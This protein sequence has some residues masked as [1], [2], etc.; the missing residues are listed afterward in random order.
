MRDRPLLYLCLVIAAAVMLSVLCGGERFVR[1]LRPSALE[2]SVPEGDLAAV[3]GQVYRIEQKENCQALYLEKNFVKYR[4]KTEREQSCREG[5][6]QEEAYQEQSIREE[7]N[8]EEAYRE[9]SVREEANQEQ[10]IREEAYQEE[11]FQ[12]SRIII[13]TDSEIQFQI[14]NRVEAKGEV[15]FFQGARNPGNFDQKRYYQ[16]L[17]IHG[18]IW[19]EDI[20]IVD[21]GVQKWKARLENFRKRWMEILL[22]NF[23]EEDG[24]VM[25]AV[26]LGEKSEVDQELKTLY[27]VNG[28]GHIIA[29][30]GLHLSFIGIGMY[31]LLRRI[32]GS[33]PIGGI[34]GILFLMLYILMIG[35]TVSA[36]RAL[37]MFLFRVGADMAGRHYDA[38]TALSAAAVVVLVWRP[39]SLYD[40]GFWLSFGAVLAIL[41]VVPVV[42]EGISMWVFHNKGQNM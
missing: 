6:V 5:S 26:M 16:I 29:I 34:F 24:G 2:S 33:Y 28:I 8:Q 23:G 14:G 13:Y 30:S 32:T 27:Q 41:A 3:I 37:V 25:G 35:F 40:G 36:V 42:H 31:K 17:D 19:A 1:E 38:P 21:T 12:E 22:S 39:L 9:Q 7:A 18:T 15:S 4:K 10:S 11:S 20:R